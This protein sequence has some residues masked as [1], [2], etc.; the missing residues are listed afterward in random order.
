MRAD[1][2]LR[3]DAPEPPEALVGVQVAVVPVEVGDDRGHVVVDRPQP[4]LADL[5]GELGPL[6][7][8]DV[9]PE[10][11]AADHRAVG[12]AIGHEIH[13]QISLLAGAPVAALEGLRRAGEHC[14]DPLARLPVRLGAEH[15][16][17]RLADNAADR[18][19]EERR[20]ARVGEAVDVVAVDV[21]DQGRQRVGHRAGAALARLEFALA[22]AQRVGR[23]GPRAELAPD[24]HV[25][26]R[27]QQRQRELCRPGER[28]DAFVMRTHARTALRE[29]LVPL[30]RSPGDD[31]TDV[32]EPPAGVR[33]PDDVD[34]LGRARCIRQ[35]DGAG[36]V[37]QHLRA[38][39]LQLPQRRVVARGDRGEL[40]FGPGQAGHRSRE[41]RG[42]P[43][44][45]V[46]DDGSIGVG[47]REAGR[48][49]GVGRDAALPGRLDR[50]VEIRGLDV[51]EERGPDER[52]C[53]TGDSP[54]KEALGSIGG[55]SGN[56]SG[57]FR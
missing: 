43:G 47:E 45:Q 25:A 55:T 26:A 16:A 32:G 35:G 41:R 37:G 3:V 53:T 39:R 52:E 34:R 15:V 19:V 33:T 49:D 14:V 54:L 1:Q 24:E 12:V 4:P 10:H 18:Q 5:L 22:R 2:A 7:I 21:A 27:E 8:G 9:E 6:A 44:Q 17:H 28:L 57:R 51:R 46:V 36:E 13:Q 48:L 40:A 11:V 50:R 29:L 23:R 42:V 20:I 30:R 38:G 56:Q 31:R